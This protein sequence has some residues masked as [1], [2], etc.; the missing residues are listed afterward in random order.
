MKKPICKIDLSGPEGNV[1]TVMAKVHA[2]LVL[3][4]QEAEAEDFF[5]QALSGQLLDR[6]E[7]PLGTY[8]D[9]L[10]LVRK[11]VELA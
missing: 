10:D 1:F 11:Y 8:Q 2:A 5:V 9:V 6:D 7:K 3:A 4:G